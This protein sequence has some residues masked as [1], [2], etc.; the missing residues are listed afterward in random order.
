MLIKTACLFYLY[1]SWGGGMR[2]KKGEGGK[3]EKQNIKET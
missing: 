2:I 1:L 3:K